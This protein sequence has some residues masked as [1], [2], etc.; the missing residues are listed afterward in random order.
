MRLRD[1][2]TDHHDR[3]AKLRL[4]RSFLDRYHVG[5]APFSVLDCCEGDGVLWDKLEKSYPCR[6]WGVDLKPKR[7]R[8]AIDSRLILGWDLAYDVVDIDTYGSPWGHWIELIAHAIRPMT[9]FLTDG[10]GKNLQGPIDPGTAVREGL[11][12]TFP[13]LEAPAILVMK[14]CPLIPARMI[15]LAG[16]HGLDVVEA[17]EMPNPKGKARYYGVR[18][19]PSGGTE[20][21]G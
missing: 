16:F 6:R 14:L 12:L 2:K 20:K 7:G 19:E 10:I 1:V 9:V 8:M 18:I 17:A 3:A 15:A 4:R 5:G 21:A 11:G 13:T